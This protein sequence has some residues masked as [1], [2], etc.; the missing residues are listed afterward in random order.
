MNDQLIITDKKIRDKIHTIRGFQVILDSDLAD[1]Y[2][3]PTK[4]LNQAVKRNIQRFPEDFMFQITELEKIEVVTN[5]DY[6][7]KMKYSPNSPF[8]FTEHGVISLSGILKS[9]KAASINIQIT[10][11]FVS[12]RKF[13]QSNARVFQRLDS[14]E[15]NQLMFQI[16]T[17]EKFEQ[18][19]NI[20]EYKTITKKQGIFYDGQVF[21]GQ[22]FDGQ[23][24]DGQVFD[25]YAFVSK[26]IKSANRSIIL[27]DNYVD[28]SVLVML[29]KRKSFLRNLH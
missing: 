18:V 7:Q 17:D 6:L 21:D 28:E 11:D 19:F 9:A 25:V 14:I 13:L 15:K 4:V 5:C 12:M 24:F 29:S 27:I 20:I 10:R 8:V 22:V 1:L 3:V 16:S 23:V 2:K 26:L